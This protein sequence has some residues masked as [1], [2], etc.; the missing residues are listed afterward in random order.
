MHFAHAAFHNS[1]IHKL[2]EIANISQ[3]K[4]VSN[5]GGDYT[6][7]MNKYLLNPKKI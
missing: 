1:T 4:S 6:I 3:V 7:S 2:T 5:V